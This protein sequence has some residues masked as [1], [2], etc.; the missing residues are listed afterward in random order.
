M[1][2]FNYLQTRGGA[3]T[4]SAPP[5]SDQS[6]VL[7]EVLEG[8]NKGGVEQSGSR[9]PRYEAVVYE[10]ARH[11]FAGTSCKS[12]SAFGAFSHNPVAVPRVWW[13]CEMIECWLTCDST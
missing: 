5:Q 9:G 11:G 7:M 12:F 13:E 10:G 3:C 6:K 1:G 4:P 8:K 2:H